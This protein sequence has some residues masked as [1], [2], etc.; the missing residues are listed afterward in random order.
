MTTNVGIGS[1]AEFWLDNSSGTLTKIGEIL[2]VP[3]PN[4]QTDDVE[5]THMDSGAYREFIAGLK[6]PG[7]G[8]FDL[9]YVPGSASDLLLA[10]AHASG[11][12]RDYEVILTKADGSQWKFAGQCYIKGIERAVPIDDRM[13]ATVTV[14]F[15][16][17]A[18]ESAV[19]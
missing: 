1:G 9:N 2:G 17:T 13:T 16:G 18:T 4:M 19:A 7:E 6:D 14:R 12:T 8:S 11:T 15:S 10:E 5:A 3:L